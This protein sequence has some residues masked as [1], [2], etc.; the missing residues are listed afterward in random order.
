MLEDHVD[1][2][3]VRRHRSDVHAAE[4]D[5]PLVGLLEAADHAKARRLPAAA[6]P[7]QG[8]ELALPDLERDGLDRL[9]VAEALGDRLENDSLLAHACERV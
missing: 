7:E 8:E 5:P 9:H 3:M 4:K 6:R 1:V 2:A